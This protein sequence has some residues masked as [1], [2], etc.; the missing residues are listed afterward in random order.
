MSEEGVKVLMGRLVADDDF[1]TS[2]FQDQ[3]LAVRRAGIQLEPN[4]I[5][6]I[7]KLQPQDLKIDVIRA[8]GV[9]AAASFSLDVRTA[10]F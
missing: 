7:S 3:R 9:G 1:R 4:E 8:G 10:K 6:A 2:F 5:Q